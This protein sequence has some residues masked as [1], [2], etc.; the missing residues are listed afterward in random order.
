MTCP[1]SFDIHGWPCPTG[2][3]M[4]RIDADAIDRRGIPGRVLMETAG[5]A[6]AEAV[7]LRFSDTRRPLIVCGGGNNGG[8]GFVV[9]RVLHELDPGCRPLVVSLADPNRQSPESRANLDLLVAAGFEIA[10]SPSEKDLV[11]LARSCD[12]AID[13][14]FG[15]GLS[16]AVEGAAADTIRAIRASGLPVVAVD[17]PSGI[18]SETGAELGIAIEADLVV[19]LGLPKLGLA[20]RPLRA[21]ILVADIGLPAESI[22]SVPVR[23]HMLT[24][25]AAARLLPSRPLEGHKGTFGHVLVAGGS[26]GKTGAPTLAALG[27]LRAGA[28]LVTAAIPARL[29]AIFEQKLTE[30][31]T[32]PVADTLAGS[33]AD[34]AGK[35][36]LR[37]LESRDAL[38]IGPGAGT[39][40]GTARAVERILSEARVPAVVDADG[41]NAFAG[42]PERLR[43]PGPRV[44]TP[45]PGELGR[46]LA[47]STAQVLADRMQSARELARRA[48]AVVVAKGARTLCVSPDGA[49]WVNPTGGPGLAT[50][51][52]GDVLAGVIGGL[53]AQGLEPLDAARLGVY[54]HGRAG[55]LG[56]AVGGLASEVATRVPLAWAELVEGERHGGSRERLARFP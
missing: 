29:N 30:A 16:R 42:R 14:I 47:R 18:S 46:L 9:A 20:L 35:E 48:H 49:V 31:M 4:G 15:V 39:S 22:A 25:R 23:Q 36:I 26:V 40:P 44:L 19:T 45:H 2:A 13:A 24:V 37:E 7:R 1:E 34:A 17:L 21:E 54:L 53:L 43:G 5:L 51:G 10:Q 50:G 52:T 56:L 41:L 27:A 32:V 8:D 3:E 12:L 55:D 6:V 33:F 11:E 38:V 28:G